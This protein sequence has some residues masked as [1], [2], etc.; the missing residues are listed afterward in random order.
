MPNTL[1]PSY[2]EH[3]AIGRDALRTLSL[4]PRQIAEGLTRCS[5]LFAQM[6]AAAT[7]P[8][9]SRVASILSPPPS[10]H[11]KKK[12]LTRAAQWRSRMA[13]VKGFCHLRLFAYEWVVPALC[14][15]G[16]YPE[17]CDVARLEAYYR[18]DFTNWG[19]Y[20]QG[21]RRGHTIVHIRGSPRSLPTPVSDRLHSLRG[22]L[23]GASHPNLPRNSGPPFPLPPAHLL[24]PGGP[25]R[26]PSRARTPQSM[27]RPPP[28]PPLPPQLYPPRPD[29]RLPRRGFSNP[30]R[31]SP[32]RPPSRA[33]PY[34]P[35]ST[36]LTARRRGSPS[37][38]ARSYK[39][40]INDALDDKILMLKSL[41]PNLPQDLSDVVWNDFLAWFMDFR[42]NPN[43]SRTGSIPAVTERFMSHYEKAKAAASNAD[44]DLSN[45]E[46]KALELSR[47]AALITSLEAELLVPQPS[48]AHRDIASDLRSAR[49]KYSVLDAEVDLLEHATEP[50]ATD[51]GDPFANQEDFVPVPEVPT[52]PW[53][54]SNYENFESRRA[55]LITPVT[56]KLPLSDLFIVMDEPINSKLFL[57]RPL[58]IY[59]ADELK[60]VN[61]S[62]FIWRHYFEDPLE[63]AKSWSQDAFSQVYSK[64]GF[65]FMI[66][67]TAQIGSM[68]RDPK[69][70]SLQSKL[71]SRW[72]CPV[73]LATMEPRQ[74]WMLCTIPDCQGP[75]AEILSAALLRLLDGNA[76]Y[77]VRHFGPPQRI[78]ELEITV[79]G[80]NA[81]AGQIFN[82][83]KKKQ[84]SFE[85]SGVSLGWRVSGIRK[86]E[87]V[88]K[89]RG[90]FILDSPSTFWSWAIHFNHA[91]GSI[92]PTTPFLD[93]EPGWVAKKPYACQLC[94]CSDHSSLECPLPH[95]RISGVSLVSHSSRTMVLHKKAAERVFITDRVLKPAPPRPSAPQDIPPPVAPLPDIPY[96]GKT[97]A[98]LSAISEAPSDPQRVRDIETFIGF[99][100][101]DIMSTGDATAIV[102][103][104]GNSGASLVLT[105]R[106]LIPR[107][108]L[109]ARWDEDAALQEFE[110][111]IENQDLD[112]PFL[113]E[114][115]GAQPTGPPPSGL[116]E[117]A[118]P[119]ADVPA[120]DRM[121]PTAPSP[122]RLI[123]LRVVPLRL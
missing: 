29:P 71:S 4:G 9:A 15:L 43:F 73:E 72:S 47:T 96:K 87:V 118:Q 121:S 67:W 99:K 20:S 101:A 5:F 84:L 55:A 42:T 92:P 31:D 85:S 46:D 123:P 48:R 81:D 21:S 59:S 60:E 30:T 51:A 86:T 44:N 36:D 97:R 33:A 63:P 76:S 22:S 104:A 112:I 62:K 14:T 3:A 53:P 56:G 26:P 1:S 34:Q 10:A 28:R 93:F 100:I 106:S 11:M 41:L 83:L 108:P 25:A 57:P 82:Q 37:A 54:E 103:S 61:K 105:I 119:P 7:L 13:S 78:R 66:A 68:S 12:G 24:A 88:S 77:I 120:S 27:P 90:T 91:H 95:M 32:R 45:L 74:D 58:E 2:L 64:P 35:Y 94:Y 52:N 23:V 122:L 50:P 115:I 17:A 98:D 80:S 40:A 75:R 79:K 6:E 39:A 89:Y 110:H 8:L 69:L 70:P 107:I 117:P 102:A 113:S 116:A 109:L 65:H 49:D 38:A 114:S 19:V 111:W 18:S 16:A